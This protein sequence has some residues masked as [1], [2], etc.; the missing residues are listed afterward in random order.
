[1]ENVTIKKS[2]VDKIRDGEPIDAADIKSVGLFNDHYIE[3]LL[4]AGQDV[5]KHKVIEGLTREGV[6]T[7][8]GGQNNEPM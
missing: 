3:M 8:E 6:Q 4:A 1:M 2:V 7:F 5:A